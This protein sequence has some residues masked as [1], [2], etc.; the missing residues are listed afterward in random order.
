MEIENRGSLNLSTI[1]NFDSRLRNTKIKDIE[2]VGELAETLQPILAVMG[3]D[4]LTE[5][6]ELI[7]DQ[8]IKELEQEIKDLKKKPVV[9]S[10]TKTK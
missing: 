1:R 2:T 3:L 4:Q 6:N 9:M 10:K 5:S 8:K 7:K